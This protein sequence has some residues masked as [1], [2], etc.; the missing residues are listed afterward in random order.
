MEYP[1]RYKNALT[2]LIQC[3]RLCLRHRHTF[4]HRRAIQ[5]TLRLPPLAATVIYGLERQYNTKS[6]KSQNVTRTLRNFADIV[7]YPSQTTTL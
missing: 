4:S 6:P 1:S 2:Y 7:L 5:S 3:R